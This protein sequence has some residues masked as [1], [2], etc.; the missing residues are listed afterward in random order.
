MFVKKI[1][2]RSG[3]T[4]IVVAEKNHG[5]YR[6]LATIG[7]ARTSVELYELEN[8]AKE[9]MRSYEERC[10][11]T[12]DFDG[13]EL[14]R[15]EAEREAADHFFSS[16]DNVQLNGCELI[17]ERVFDLIGFNAISDDVFRHL[18]LS[19]LSHPASKA[20]TVEYLK[21]YFDN[22]V[23]LSKIY[24]Y[25]NKLADSQKSLVESISVMHTKQ[26]LGG[27][28]GV[29]FYD[30]TTI[31]FETDTQDDL[32][33][34]GFSKEGRHRNP[35]IILGLLVS[36]EGYPLAY[37]VHEGNKFEGHTMLPVINEFVAKYGI[38]GFTVV[39]DSGLMNEGNIRDLEVNH[40]NYIIGNRIKNESDT[41]KKQILSLPKRD[42]AMHEIDKGDGRRLLVG[43]SEK[44][45]HKDAENRKEGVKRLEKN[46]KSGKLTKENVN[47]RG[48]NKFLHITGDTKVEIN[49]ERIEQDAQWDGLKGY[50]TNTDKPT[51][52]IYEYYHDLW[53]VERS[54]RIAKN[55][56]EIRPVFHFTRKRI[57]AHI[58]ICFVALK[59]Y[60]ELERLLKRS[61][62]D[63]SVDKVLAM[64]KTVTT[65]SMKLPSGNKVS[66]TVLLKRH[67][68]IKK[69]FLDDFWGMQ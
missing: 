15:K 54:F 19:R 29:V 61:G 66:R 4:S 60:K 51:A 27:T 34:T 46:Y 22:D 50:I 58:C 68:K 20:A 63:M 17:L 57:D 36:M 42:G 26:V 8:R 24:R 45:A 30:V 18:V 38:D 43:Y 31:Y 32:R 48:Y 69:L 59:V 3:S 10:H 49:Y 6:R 39:A 5:K 40:Y 9:W 44:R 28:V 33:K 1:K 62:I 11:P 53:N 56:I 13:R 65:I 25:L 16:I 67:N 12:L 35:Q 7:V 14:M 41:I 52:E 23:N 21:N 2:N 47:R 55:K 64:A 37:C